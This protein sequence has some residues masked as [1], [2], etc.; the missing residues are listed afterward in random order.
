MS[1]ISRYAISSGFHDAK[2]LDLLCLVLRCWTF[3]TSSQGAW[4]PLDHVKVSD[5]FP[6]CY[7]V[8]SQ[9]PTA[10]PLRNPPYL[11]LLGV[12]H[13]H[14]F[15]FWSF[16]LVFTMLRC[17]IFSTSCFTAWPEQLH[18]IRFQVK[19][20]LHAAWSW[21]HV[22]GLLDLVFLMLC[23]LIFPASGHAAWSS[24]NYVW[25]DLHGATLLD[26]VYLMLR[27][28]TFPAICVMLLDGPYFMLW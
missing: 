5:H 14:A 16:D 18:V 9:S 6:R 3:P 15:V 7:I 10:T 26:G 27:Y 19:H 22:A 12:F 24:L 11:L 20:I 28:W 23:C 4:C 17:L 25:F 2:L 1:S 8:W 21:L 13:N